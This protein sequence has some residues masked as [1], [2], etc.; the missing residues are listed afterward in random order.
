MFPLLVGADSKVLQHL[1]GEGIA[2]L[3]G[4][5]ANLQVGTILLTSQAFGERR[6]PSS[7]A[8]AAMCHS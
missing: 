7:T 3:V 5:L 8:A 4:V 2:R 6:G 1:D